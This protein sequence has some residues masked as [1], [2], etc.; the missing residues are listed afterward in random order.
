MPSSSANPLTVRAS[1][2]SDL[3]TCQGLG[4]SITGGTSPYTI[5]VVNLT[6]DKHTTISG[7]SGQDRL[8][9]INRVDPNGMMLGETE[10]VNSGPILYR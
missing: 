1:T 7:S 8:T 3:Q 5:T 10:S 4:L 6:K 2:T 9:Y